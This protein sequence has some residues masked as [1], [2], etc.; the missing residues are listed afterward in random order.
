MERLDRLAQI[1]LRRFSGKIHG[2]F[3]R[4]ANRDIGKT[5]FLSSARRCGST[6]VSDIVNYRRDYRYVFEPFNRAS[7]PEARCFCWVPY[8]RAGD[9]GTPEQR[10]Y[11]QRVLDGSFRSRFLDQLN[12]TFFPQKRVIKG[13]RSNLILKW[14][15]INFP[16]FK[17]ILLIRHPFAMAASMERMTW[18]LDLTKFMNQQALVED[19]LDPVLDDLKNVK[20]RFLTAV[21]SWCVEYAVAISELEPEDALVVFYEDA[22]VH[23]EREARRILDYIGEPFSERV[24]HQM[25]KPSATASRQSAIVTGGDLTNAWK[26]KILPENAEAGRALLEKFGL[27]GFYDENSNPAYQDFWSKAKAVL[28]VGPGRG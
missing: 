2:R 13:V 25:K 20:G 6:W 9:P 1:A 10:D 27:D 28:K 11:C 19:Y 24:L 21:A 26:E 23:P 3:F 14:L 4:D 8:M 5:V 7:I 16:E 18:A 17:A 12:P 22:V 15:K